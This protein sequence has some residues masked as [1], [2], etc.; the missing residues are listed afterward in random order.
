MGSRVGSGLLRLR[1]DV[2]STFPQAV[3]C[4]SITLRRAT[5]AAVAPWHHRRL[6]LGR[7]RRCQVVEAFKRDGGAHTLDNDFLNDGGP[8]PG[9]GQ[10]LDPVS[11][12]D[13]LSGF[14]LGA[15]DPHVAGAACSGGHG[16]TLVK[17]HRRRPDV[18]AR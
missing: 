1:S 14:S 10:R 2:R 13:R 16:A 17:P 8:Q 9:V 12:V 15:V 5:C 6:F 7:W 4:P 18:C 11:D 3:E